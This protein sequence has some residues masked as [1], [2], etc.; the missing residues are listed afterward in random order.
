VQAIAKDGLLFVTFA[1]HHYTQFA[2]TWVHHMRRNNVTNFIIGCMDEQILYNLAKRG[3]YTLSM[4]SGRWY[5][6]GGGD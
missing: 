1:N 2:L 3:V 6:G 5:A 4:K